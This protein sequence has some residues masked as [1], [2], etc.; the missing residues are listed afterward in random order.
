MKSQN[1]IAR[2]FGV[3]FLLAFLS[4]GIGTGLTTSVT[5]AADAL[6]NFSM[7]KTSLITG[8][9]LMA[10]VHTI[11]N[12]GLPVLMVPIL[13][14]YNKILSYGYLSAGITATVI[15]IIGAVFLMM[16][17]P[18]SS[19]Y[20]NADEADVGYF[21]T[22]A[23]ILTKVNFYAYQIGMTIW[24][25]GGLM[26]CYLLYISKLVPKGLSIWGFLGYM[27]FI[28]GTISELFSSN[29]GVQLS[30][31][32]GLFEITLSIWLI[33]KGFKESELIKS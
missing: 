7:H 31:P 5:G 3:F 30:I 15:L 25:F 20:V 29:I 17:V 1:T 33:I 19:M 22:I 24:G 12:I 8:V 9:I 32:G 2:T 18:L 16:F 6:S 27:V 21:E 11:V 10:L 28:A 26:F 4:Y 13:K 14:P 23:A